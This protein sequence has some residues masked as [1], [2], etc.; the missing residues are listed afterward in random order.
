MKK[1][2]VNLLLFVPILGIQ[3][4]QE[5]TERWFRPINVS[6]DEHKDAIVEKDTIRFFKGEWLEV[7]AK[8]QGD[9][10]LGKDTLFVDAQKLTN[11]KDGQSANSYH[12]LK[13]KCTASGDSLIKVFH[14]GKDT[15]S[16][17]VIIQTRNEKLISEFKVP[18]V[19]KLKE[20]K[21]TLE[22]T[23]ILRFS[24]EKKA[25]VVFEVGKIE[26]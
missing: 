26:G 7:V 17:M 6:N 9:V 20:L 21:V 2:L 24:P 4:Q 22:K 25:A 10:L 15:V 23:D 1:L 16:C 13:L 8:G 11:W 19:I 5:N 18:G 12:P 14:E 3:A